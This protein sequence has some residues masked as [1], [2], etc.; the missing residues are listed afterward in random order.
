MTGLTFDN[1]GDGYTAIGSCYGSGDD[2]NDNNAGIHPFG[3]YLGD[4]IDQDCNGVD[5]TPWHP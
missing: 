1:D 5:L 3:E 4:G 2:C